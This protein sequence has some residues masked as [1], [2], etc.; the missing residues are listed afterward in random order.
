MPKRRRIRKRQ[1]I[2]KTPKRPDLYVGLILE[3]ADAFHARTQRWPNINSG[4]IVETVDDTWRRIDDSLR[5]GHRGLPRDSRLSLARLLE[6]F[7]G[8]RNSE[9]PPKLTIA[10]IVSWAKAHRRRTGWWPTEKCGS[11]VGV[12]GETWVAIDLSLRR[13]RRGLRS[14]SSLA[15][16]LE[17]RLGVRNLA[18]VPRLKF[19]RI[20]WWADAFHR[21][22]GR[23]PTRE[24]GAIEGTRG[25]TWYA[26]NSALK[27]GRRGLPGGSSLAK[28]LA[29][30]RGVRRSR[31]DRPSLT[32]EQILHWCDIYK[33]RHG[34]WP[35]Q[36]SGPI[37]NT[38]SETWGA[39]NAAL[40]HGLRGLR[41]GSSLAQLLNEHG[42]RN[43]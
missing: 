10:Q 35:T 14:R 21:R 43:E 39:I 33:R 25:E 23:W 7:R 12:P 22:T 40:R 26:M 9:Y 41:G 42:R 5:H 4:R 24:S 6:K 17:K 37:D 19:G 31:S 2:R 15:R 27:I 20:L 28:L 34:T 36:R 30:K 18:N 11:I 38:A 3:W 1:R 16:L 29:R 13:G 32:P 8:V